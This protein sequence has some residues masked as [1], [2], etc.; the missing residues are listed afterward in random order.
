M[1]SSASQL[2]RR[3]MQQDSTTRGTACVAVGAGVQSE[4]C[5]SG[6]QTQSST[7]VYP[8]YMSSAPQQALCW[9]G[10]RDV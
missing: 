6:N 3:C 8:L 2:P 9:Q 1:H 10:F 5:L 4:L 7:A